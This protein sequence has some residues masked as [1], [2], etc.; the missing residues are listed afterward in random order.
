MRSA[1]DATQEQDNRATFN[2]RLST[3][4]KA[5]LQ[6]AADLR[7][8]SLSEFVLGAAYDRAAETIEQNTVL[9]LTTR[10]AEAFAA[11]LDA[12]PAVDPAVVD[13]FVHAH[14]RSRRLSPA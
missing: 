8:Q 1:P 11:A 7:G 9:R 12:A 14:R 6:R 13:R 5:L 4:V 3:D 2:T 10:D